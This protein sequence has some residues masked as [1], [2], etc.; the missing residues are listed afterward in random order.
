MK[1]Q[2]ETFYVV[3]W[4]GYEAA[5]WTPPGLTPLPFCPPPSRGGVTVGDP[6]HFRE[7]GLTKEDGHSELIN[8]YVLS[9][10]GPFL[11][12]LSITII[13]RYHHFIASSNALPAVMFCLIG[14]RVS[15]TEDCRLTYLR[16][17]VSMC[18]SPSN[19]CPLTHFVTAM[20]SLN[21]FI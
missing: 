14:P 5:P 8:S 10:A 16:W 2:S 15:G 19:C 12:F 20:G 7:W 1:N 4:F 18:P 9:Q 21:G 13:S 3:L 17:W 11:C 6:G